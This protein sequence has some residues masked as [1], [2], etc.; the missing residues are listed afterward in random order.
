MKKLGWRRRHYA[1]VI[2][3][4]SI[5][6]IMLALIAG[7]VGCFRFF[8]LYEIRD[9]YDLDN[10]KDNLYGTYLLMNDLDATTAGYTELASSTAN[11]GQGW[12]PIG[13]EEASFRG[14][15]SGQGHEI[16]ELFINR[17][18]QERV[19]LFNELGITGRIMSLGVVKANVTGFSLVGGLAGMN[20]GNVTGCYVTGSV[21]STGTSRIGGLVGENIATV[22][23]CYSEASVFGN[24]HVGGLVGRNWNTVSNSYATNNVTGNLYVGGLVGSNEGNVSGSYATGS[25]SGNEQV[26]G[27]VGD[28]NGTVSTSFW[29]IQTSGQTTSAGGTGE[30]TA[31]MMNIATFSGATWNIIAVTDLGARNPSYI[32]NIVTGLTYPFLS[33]Q[34]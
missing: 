20:F 6:L 7:M 34:A 8:G 24:E 3:I 18:D 13:M 15:L 21:S 16:K 27:L 29:D 22:D 32:W 25:V 9:W 14:L 2:G 28:S 30:N 12:Q 31:Q 11:G 5:F 19:G 17:P 23:N 1:A 4:F 26:G 10:I 33:W